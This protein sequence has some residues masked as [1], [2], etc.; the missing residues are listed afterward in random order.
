[1]HGAFVTHVDAAER[2]NSKYGGIGSIDTASI[3]TLLGKTTGDILPDANYT[4][5]VALR[6][7]SSGG[8]K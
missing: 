2:I 3:L 6:V 1:L 4:N 5:D 7:T 8:M